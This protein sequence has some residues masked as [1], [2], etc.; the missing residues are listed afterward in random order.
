MFFDLWGPL[1]SFRY[2]CDFV[3]FNFAVNVCLFVCDLSSNSRIYHSY[4]DVTISFEGLQI[5]T[6]ARH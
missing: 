2:K 3:I 6:Y 5:L 4:G 1:I